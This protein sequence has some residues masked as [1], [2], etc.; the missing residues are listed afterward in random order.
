MPTAIIIKRTKQMILRAQ[1][2][3]V[4]MAAIKIIG[5]DT[6]TLFFGF[7]WKVLIHTEKSFEQKSKVEMEYPVL[8]EWMNKWIIQ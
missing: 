7:Q 2:G 3:L 8:T 6:K 1:I 5:K 4:H